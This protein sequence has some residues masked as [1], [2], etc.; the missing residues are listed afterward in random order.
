MPQSR[1]DKVV[2][3]FNWGE[4]GQEGVPDKTTITADHFYARWSGTYEA[5][6]NEDTRFEIRGGFPWRAKGQP[7]WVGAFWP[8]WR[9]GL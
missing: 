3:H 5:A 7:L 2:V 4:G 9:V 1:I 8:G 6:T